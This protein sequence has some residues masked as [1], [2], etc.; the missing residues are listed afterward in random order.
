MLLFQCVMCNQYI[1]D[2]KVKDGTTPLGINISVVV[3]GVKKTKVWPFINYIL[4]LS[5]S[6][7]KSST[8]LIYIAIFRVKQLQFQVIDKNEVENKI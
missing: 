8:N 6:V 7:Y 2:S 4:A 5:I 3:F 1:I